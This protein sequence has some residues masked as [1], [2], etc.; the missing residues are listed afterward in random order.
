MPN[1]WIGIMAAAFVVALATWLALVFYAD[2]HPNKSAHP[3][4]PHRSVMGGSFEANQGGRQV[5]P[6]P[7][8]DLLPERETEARREIVPAQRQGREP[9]PGQRV[10]SAAERESEPAGPSPRA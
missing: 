9:V 10:P 6:D 8:E 7:G 3:S 4:A 2:S 5:M 1:Y